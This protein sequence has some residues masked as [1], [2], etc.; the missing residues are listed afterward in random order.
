MWTRL[1]SGRPGVSA[2]T[3]LDVDHLRE[4]VKVGCATGDITLLLALVIATVLGCFL[5][6]L[7]SA[8]RILPD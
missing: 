3:A 7:S 1:R 4:T 2:A 8:G 5:K 6:R